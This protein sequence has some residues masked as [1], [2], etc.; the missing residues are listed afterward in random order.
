M[1]GWLSVWAGCSGSILVEDAPFALGADAFCVSVI[2]ASMSTSI[3]GSLGASFVVGC[4]G[5][6]ED[7]AMDGL[8]QDAGG[9]RSC[10]T[11]ARKG[12]INSDIV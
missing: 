3:S 1:D 2:S 10:R 12:D 8:V 11:I 4:A 7:M 6:G 9:T 5:E